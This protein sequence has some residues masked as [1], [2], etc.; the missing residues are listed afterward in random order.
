MRS[1]SILGGGN[2]LTLGTSSIINGTAHGFGADTFQ[3][4]GTGTAT[5]DAGLFATQYSGYTTF[6]KVGA[7]TWTLT[8]TGSNQ[9]WNIT[10]GTLVAAHVSA[11]TID[12]LGTG[13]ITMNGGTL[14]S[15]VTGT[16]FNNLTFADGTSSTVSAAA[17]QTVTFDA[18][19]HLY[20]RKR[21]APTPLSAR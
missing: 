9:A 2:T 14:R 5:L 15:T 8:G 7:S 12:A 16:F 21:P 13:D 10:D 6:N 4:G 1:V 20:A 17:G 18:A 3:L 11:G 19:R